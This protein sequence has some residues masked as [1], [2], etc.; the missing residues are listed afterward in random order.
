MAKKHTVIHLLEYLGLKAALAVFGVM[1]LD[2]ASAAG[3]RLARFVGPKTGVSNRA[4]ANIRRV[5]PD[6]SPEEIERIIADMWENLGRTVGEYA[7]LERFTRP[8]ERHRIEVVHAGALR[9][10]AAS[11]NGGVFISGHFSNWELLPLVMRLEGLEGGDV[12]RRANNPFVNEWMV[13]LRESITGGAIQIPKGGVGAR[14]IVRLMRENKFVAMLADQ[15]MNDGVE[16]RLFGLRAMTTGAPAGL[17]VRYNVPIVP[18]CIERLKGAHFRITV[19]NPIT[20]RPGADPFE[21]VMRITQ[22]INDF[23]EARIRERPHEWFWMH[24]RWS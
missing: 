13:S 23:L 18:A 17:A 6:L 5:M 16:A 20:A 14:L 12:Y 9:S 1:G 2:R 11:G 19:Y 4:R 22:E 3:G 15:K 8:E 21:D 7:H 10:I 24:N